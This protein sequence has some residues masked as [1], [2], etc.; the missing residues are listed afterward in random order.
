MCL[1]LLYVAVIKHRSKATYGGK[2]LFQ[3]TLPG[4]NPSL[5]EAK[6]GTLEQ[7][8]KQRPHGSATYWLPSYGFTQP[9]FLNSSEPPAQ[10]CA[11]QCAGPSHSNH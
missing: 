11:D 7:Q 3:L 5:R 1:S 10:G 9:N 2:G 4:H 8:L 6:A